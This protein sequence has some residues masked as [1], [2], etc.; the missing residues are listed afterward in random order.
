[1]P[2]AGVSKEQP[3]CRQAS[4]GGQGVQ[5]RRYAVLQSPRMAGPAG[6]VR[7]VRSNMRIRA[8]TNHPPGAEFNMLPRAICFRECEVFA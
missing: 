8:I 7:Y 3:G 5:G 4:E 6:L 2:A 1:M